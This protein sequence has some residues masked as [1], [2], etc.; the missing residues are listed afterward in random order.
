[1]S[2]STPSHQPDALLAHIVAY[3]LLAPLAALAAFWV[4]TGLF[5]KLLVLFGLVWLRRR[6]RKRR[7]PRRSSGRISLIRVFAPA[8]VLVIMDEG[9]AVSL[10][11]FHFLTFF[12]FKGCFGLPRYWPEFMGNQRWSRN[13]QS[14]GT[15]SAAPRLITTRQH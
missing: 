3:I 12:S 8:S 1:M 9:V 2:N 15:R 7:G 14:H 13:F 5:T 11:A 4:Y 10:F 6:L